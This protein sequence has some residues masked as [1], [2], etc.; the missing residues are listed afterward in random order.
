MSY[1]TKT[2][3]GSVCKAILQYCA[4]SHP[5]EERTLTLD[6]PVKIGRLLAKA[7]VSPNNGIFDCK[8]LSRNHA[9]LWHENNK[10]FLQDTKSSNGTFVNNHRL[11]K[12]GEESKP[13]EVFSGDVVQFGVDVI[14]NARN[15]S[16]G[17]ITAI[18]K[19]YYADGTEAKSNPVVNFISDVSTQ[20]LYN[21]DA[22]IREALHREANLENKLLS[23]EKLLSNIIGE[24]DNSW[25][26]LVAEDRLLSKIEFL[27]NQLQYYKKDVSE[28][29]MRQEICDLKQYKYSYQGMAKDC[30]KKEMEDKLKLM[31]KCQELENL[32]KHSTT[33]QSALMKHL[34]DA[35]TE[36]KDMCAK[37]NTEVS[38]HE[39][40]VKE[41][42]VT[43]EHFETQI[44]TLNEAKNEIET[45]FRNRCDEVEQLRNEVKKMNY[46]VNTRNILLLTLQN[47]HKLTEDISLNE[48][49]NNIMSNVVNILQDRQTCLS[50]LNSLQ[51]QMKNLIKQKSDIEN[52]VCQLQ[53]ELDLNRDLLMKCV[54]DKN[55]TEI[56]NMDPEQLKMI[57]LN[58]DDLKNI[59]DFSKDIE[60]QTEFY[61][62]KC[63][64]IER[65]LSESKDVSQDCI[66]NLDN[67]ELA[68]K[69]Q[70]RELS[71]KDNIL[72]LMSDC[73]YR[74]SIVDTS[75]LSTI[76]DTIQ[77]YLEFFKNST[78]INIILDDCKTS[79]SEN[80]KIESKT[81][82]DDIENKTLP[83]SQTDGYSI[84]DVSS[85]TTESKE[86]SKLIDNDVEQ[87]RM[88][89]DLCVKEKNTL[90]NELEQVMLKCKELEQ[91]PNFHLFFA[92]PSIV[93]FLVLVIQF[94]S[95]L[96][97]L[98]GT[99]E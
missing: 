3:T 58:E 77:K 80:F 6:Q 72:L 96:S 13:Q 64:E 32:L 15:I 71:C 18:L 16:H 12:S 52:Q 45:S 20:D 42:D 46:E 39:N 86:D 49:F 74:M 2:V 27:E 62:Q 22:Y 79:H 87:I 10:F 67:Q 7:K 99:T 69:R 24:T 50:Q 91:Y 51:N 97:Y 68:I 53:T 31:Q 48:Y 25:K 29:D 28:D 19:L 5:F 88:E 70:K 26:A 55:V 8:V 92:L 30:L 17:C 47:E 73:L 4:N 11:S 84:Q 81:F 57:I 35:Q 14:E 36:I 54:K 63:E 94:Y 9:L 41:F 43:K 82:K 78:N 83:D 23:L 61:K 60:I 65:R 44:K 93:L 37:L 40:T 90:K 38:N 59:E 98:T 34:N 1:D 95:Y 89:Y 21:I 33:E 75:N 85:V 56:S 76:P 66:K